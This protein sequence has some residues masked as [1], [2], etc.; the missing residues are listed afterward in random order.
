[1][2][3]I[4]IIVPGSRPWHWQKLLID[5]LERQGHDVGVQAHPG[6]SGVP[7]ML[8]AMLGL[9]RRAFR[10]KGVALASPAEIAEMPR[11]RRPSLRID[12]T[13]G[14]LRSDV[15]TL[16]PAFDGSPSPGRIVAVLAEGRLPA[17]EA[18]RDGEIPA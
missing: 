13:G 5:R 14:A 7:F 6:T 16:T 18:V 12:L 15:P 9:E 4:D 3:A 10:R 17:I 2:L 1:M 8:D 11:T